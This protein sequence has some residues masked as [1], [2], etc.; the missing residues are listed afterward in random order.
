MADIYKRSKLITFGMAAIAGG[1]LVL[2]MLFLGSFFADFHLA[3]YNEPG[4]WFV[5]AF[6]AFV[7]AQIIGAFFIMMTQGKNTETSLL[8]EDMTMIVVS[9]ASLAFGITASIYIG[10]RWKE[11]VF[12]GGSKSPN[13]VY[14]CKDFEYA[15]WFQFI[16]VIIYVLF[17][18]FVG[19][20]TYAWDFYKVFQ[21]RN[22][23]KSQRADDDEDFTEGGYDDEEAY[24]SF[25]KG[26]T[27]RRKK[28]ASIRY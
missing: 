15:I 5:F 12:G 26:S 7:P 2:L 28:G 3:D 19:I 20:A 1:G 23:L 18:G 27:Q 4:H 21:F 13:E 11:C 8:I 10:Q 16:G 14:W 25:P 24:A 17:H 9:V 22:A 6:F